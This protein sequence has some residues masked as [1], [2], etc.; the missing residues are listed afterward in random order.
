MTTTMSPRTWL[1]GADGRWIVGEQGTIMRRD[2]SR[3]NI[4]DSNTNEDLCGVVELDATNAW[5]VGAAGT[6]VH[7]D[8]H[9]WTAVASPTTKPLTA[10]WASAADRVFAAGALTI[11][12]ATPG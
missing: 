11:V 7:W 2:G 5:A 6:I 1:G 9:A 10:V 3:W 8:G 4:V 12:L